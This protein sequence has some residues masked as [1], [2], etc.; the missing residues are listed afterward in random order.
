[1]KL[2]NMTVAILAADGFE[3]IELVEPR[4]ALEQAGATAKIVSPADKEVQGWNHFDKADLF[5]VDVPLEKANAD[6]F[7]ALLK[8]FTILEMVRTGKVLITRGRQET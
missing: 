2:K 8:K 3:Q 4:K 6:E 1:M 5:P 7:E